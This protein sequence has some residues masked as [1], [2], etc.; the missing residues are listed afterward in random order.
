M[1]RYIE[2]EPGVRLWTEQRGPADAPPLLLIMGAQS[3]GLGWPDAL[4]ETLAADHR[5]VRYDHRDTGKS[6]WSYATR[7]YRIA[8]LAE[9][10]RAVLDGLGIARAHVVGMSLGGILTQLLMAD[11]PERLLSATLLATIA[12]SETPFARAD[13]STVPVAELPGVAPWLDEEMARP[14]AGPGLDAELDRRIRLWRVLASAELPFDEQHFR[15]LE[16]GIIE[17]TGS[18]DIS[19]AF[20]AADQSGLLRTEAL[21]ATE[22]P[23]LVLA[24]T[25]DP[26]FPPPHP[27]HLAQCVRGA[28]LLEIPGLGHALPPALFGPLTDAILAHTAG[29][30]EST[31]PAGTAHRQD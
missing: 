9:D 15:E 26:L 3:S 4:V 17:H 20:A 28:R 24:A 7:P 11:H 2:V 14:A 30:R 29:T 27:W 25:A 22:V 6:T 12:V 1:V 5:V 23:T 21:A 19:E 10:A 8:E 13:G 31:A 18:Q 16:R